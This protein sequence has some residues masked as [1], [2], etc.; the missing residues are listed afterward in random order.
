M[1]NCW[2]KKGNTKAEENK[3]MRDICYERYNRGLQGGNQASRRNCLL[4]TDRKEWN[5]KIVI[6]GR[7]TGMADQ[8]A[9][10]HESK[11]RDD[12]SESR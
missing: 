10:H 2:L 8:T 12:P 11:D 1:R 3:E 9:V 6:K 7:Q 5:V 4:S